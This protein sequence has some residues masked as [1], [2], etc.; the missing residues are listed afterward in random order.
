VNRWSDV[1]FA[2]WVAA[3]AAAFV[4]TLYLIFTYPIH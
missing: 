1:G 3:S 4:G 2:F